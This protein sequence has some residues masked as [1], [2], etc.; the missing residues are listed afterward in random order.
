MK[1]VVRNCNF[2]AEISINRFLFREHYKI[3]EM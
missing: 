1:I 2:D 3:V